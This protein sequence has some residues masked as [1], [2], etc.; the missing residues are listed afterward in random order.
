[1]KKILLTICCFVLMG[2]C[3]LSE[4]FA[5]VASDVEQEPEVQEY[6]RRQTEYKRARSTEPELSD[7]YDVYDEDNFWK[8]KEMR[9]KEQEAEYKRFKKEWAEFILKLGTV[10]NGMKISV[11]VL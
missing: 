7:H 2:G 8:Q 3:S 1:M 6:Q 9:E 5:L 4:N 11:N 10:T